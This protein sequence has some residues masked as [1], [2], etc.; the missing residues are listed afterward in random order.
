MVPAE[1]GSGSVGRTWSGRTLADSWDRSWYGF[2]TT[3]TTWQEV[4][5]RPGC[6]WQLLPG[7]LCELGG[8][9]PL[10]E[11]SFVFRKTETS[12]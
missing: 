12:D 10:P 8:S 11:P 1:V 6:E 9:P 2:P 4:S 7:G 5:A 3:S